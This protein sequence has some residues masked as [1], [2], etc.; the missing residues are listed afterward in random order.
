[1]LGVQ[2]MVAIKTEYLGAVSEHLLPYF[3]GFAMANRKPLPS[4][5]NGVRV[6]SDCGM[7]YPKKNSRTKVRLAIV[8]CGDCKKHRKVNAYSIS[9]LCPSCSTKGELNGSYTHGGWARGRER[10]YGIWG[11]MKQRCERVENHDYKNYGGRGIRICEEWQD[12]AKFKAWAGEQLEDKRM[13]IERLDSSGDYSPSNCSVL[14]THL[15][16]YNRRNGID[17]NTAVAFAL[18]VE[19]N[20]LLYGN[21]R[22]EKGYIMR[23]MDMFGLKDYQIYSFVNNS[24][25]TKELATYAK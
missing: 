11:G 9:K 17:F 4:E 22:G 6:I 5:I 15:Q 24:K 18:E 13:S 12:Y 10:T 14:P 19:N 25:H 8:E 7:G 2:T 20:L 3:K 1:M 23:Y 16:A 21:R